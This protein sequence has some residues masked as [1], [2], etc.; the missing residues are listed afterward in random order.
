MV[1]LVPIQELF[2]LE[3]HI[4]SCHAVAR[5]M[6]NTKNETPSNNINELTEYS[7]NNVIDMG[8]VVIK[9][10]KYTEKNKKQ[11]A[12]NNNPDR[13]AKAPKIYL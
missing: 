4:S 12:R 9:T 1:K 13:K 3:T 7:S 11:G 8:K 2:F 6:I 10:F 5:P